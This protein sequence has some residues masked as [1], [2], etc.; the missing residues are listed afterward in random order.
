[1]KHT[2][3]T[4]IMLPVIF[5]GLAC[6]AQSAAPPQSPA[7]PEF[8]AASVKLATEDSLPA[9]GRRIQTTL[10]TLTTHGLSLRACIL[11]A[12]GMPAQVIGPDWLNDVRL[13]IVAKATKPVGDKQLYAMLKTLLIERMG[14]KTHVE[15]R[16][17]PVYALTIAKGG[18]KFPESTTEGPEVTRQEKGAVIIQRASLSELAAE[19]SGKGFDRP[20]IDAT[21]LTG[22]YDVRLDM[23]AI[24]T[25]N[26]ANPSDPAGTMMGA[27]EDQMG[28]KVVSRKAPL[29]VLVIDHAERKPAEN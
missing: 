25:A 7:A 18:P 24:A 8:D 21:G 15:K 9:G 6:L 10:N 26:Q 22:R 4:T 19:L 28:L 16:E 1:M 14:L 3:N 17:M 20:V 29:D 11:W 2:S 13:D 12:Y 27:L 5:A 23:A